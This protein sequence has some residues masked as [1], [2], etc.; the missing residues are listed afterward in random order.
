MEQ[1]IEFALKALR[2][3]NFRELCREYGISTKT[4]YKWRERLLTHGWAGLQELSRRPHAQPQGLGEAVVCDIVR[5]KQA[6]P[7][8]GPRKIQALYA[9]QHE[10]EVPSESSFKRVL[11]RAGLTVPRRVRRAAESGRLSSGIK[12][13][14]PNDVWTV[15]FKGWWKD[16]A[17]LRV[18]PLTV[19]DEHSRM[20]LEMRVL[21]NSRTESVR[22]CF[23]RLFERHGLP[24]AIRSDNGAPFAS[25]NGLLGL[26]RLSAW[27]LALGIDLERSRPGCPQ[28]NGAHE[29]LH[30]DV[31]RELEAG[32]IGRDQAAFDLWRDQYNTQRPH[33]ALGMR[34]P[35]EVYR[36]SARAYA[37]TPADLDYGGMQTRKVTRNTGEICYRNAGILISAALGG[38]SVGLSTREDGLV[39]V[40]FSKLLLGHL[41]PTTASFQSARSD[42]LKAGQT[43][44][45]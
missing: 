41:D 21:E 10:G 30:R 7:H 3:L 14:Q 31:R 36:P 8:W 15:D 27:W 33:E 2:T 45:E 38:W 18:E 5:L 22:G 16:R 28:D 23:E 11:E 26:S 19:R 29:R 43:N 39:E 17:G 6:H 34:V 9:R 24:G 25:A 12:A 40:W 42:G 37:G 13:E 20:L 1:R 4:G 35:A 44:P 32:R